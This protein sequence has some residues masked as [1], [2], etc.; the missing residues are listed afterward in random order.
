MSSII[1]VKSSFSIEETLVKVKT[2]L[3]KRN[4]GVLWEINFKDKFEEKGLNYKY[5]YWILEVCNPQI[6]IGV[7]ETNQ[8]AGY[9]LP[10]KVAIFES[11][12]GVKAGLVKPDQ[13]IGIVDNS[14][15]MLEKASQV[16]EILSS[17]I[18]AA[19]K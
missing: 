17:A 16:A 10:C 19:M 3:A 7:I 5:N 11:E 6:A 15:D 12:D 18:N 13:L 4:F 1:E 2:E 8:S 9:F 14:P